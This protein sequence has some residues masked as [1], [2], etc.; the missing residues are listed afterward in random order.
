[1]TTWTSVLIA[2]AGP[3]GLTLAIELARRHIP[4]RIV[5]AASGPFPG[6][7]G[8]GLQPRTLEVFEDLGVLDAI[9]S[10]GGPYPRFRVHLGP[11]SI[12]AGG[13]HKVLPPES[14]RAVPEPLDGAA[15]AY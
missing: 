3:T 14:L 6:S 12:P 15:V 5:D 13:L 10:A 1:M 11:L 8:K 4:V 7:R 9:R 2:G